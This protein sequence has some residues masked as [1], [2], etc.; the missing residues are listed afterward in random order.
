MTSIWSLL[1][2]CFHILEVSLAKPFIYLFIFPE[3]YSETVVKALVKIYG[4]DAISK[5][6]YSIVEEDRLTWPK[7]PTFRLVITLFFQFSNCL[8][9]NFHRIQKIWWHLPS[10]PFIFSSLSCTFLTIQMLLEWTINNLEVASDS[11]FLITLAWN[12][13][14]VKNEF[15][16]YYYLYFF[17][18]YFIYIPN[19]I[20][21]IHPYSCWYTLLDVT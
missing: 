8:I 17:F 21:R 12:L 18:I 4:F 13:D 20:L 19:F 10:F 14:D 7:L 3:S 9:Q 16:F 6:Y 5:T 11:L 1:R 15:I 2:F